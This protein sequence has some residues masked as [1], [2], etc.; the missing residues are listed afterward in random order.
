[1]RPHQPLLVALS[2]LALGGC[3]PSPMPTFEE[4][5]F[6]EA[7]AFL[8]VGGTSAD[9]VW[10][11]GAQT[12]PLG[13]PILLHREGGAWEEVPVPDTLH[14]LWWVHAFESGPVFVGGA[15]ATVLR[16]DGDTVERTPTPPFFGNTVFGVWGASPDDV[17]AVGGFAGRDAFAWHWDGAAWDVIDLPDNLPRTT[18]GE[19]PA[20]F[21]VWGR[22]TDDV[23]M[24][25]GLGLVLHWDGTSLTRVMSGTSGDLFTITGT[26]AEV[27]VVGGRQGNGLLLRGGM[28]GFVDDTP[29]GTQLIQAATFDHEGTLWVA[30]ASGFAARQEEGGSWESVDLGFATPPQVV[31]SM[32]TD[33]EGGVWGAGGRAL[34]PE[35]D[36]GVL[37]APEGTD[38]WTPT[39]EPAPD[40]SCPADLVDIAP[41]QS[42]A[43][44]WMELL[45]DSI[46]RDIPHPPVH[47]RNLHHV[48]VAMYDAWAT[49]QEVADGVVYTDRHTAADIESARQ[50][51]ISHAAYQVL[52]HRYAGAVGAETSLDCYD[53]FMADVL[54]LD[55]GDD[56]VTG[57]DPVA[58]GNRIGLAV[59]E[60]FASDGANEAGGYEDTTGWA[61]AN[62]V[63]VVDLPGTNVE[64]PD[65]WQ[66]LNLGTAETQNG[67]V[68]DSSVQPYIGPHWREVEPFAI[69]PD[70]QTG[71]YS[72]SLGAAPGVA[73]PVT[74]EEVVQVIRKT[75]ELDVDDGV[76]IDIGPGSLGN[77]SLGADDGAGYVLNPVTGEP[78]APN[79]VPRGDFTRVVAEIWADG[80]KSTTPPG[81][82]MGLANEVSDELSASELIPFGAGEPVDRLSWDV[83]LYLTVSGAVHDAAISAWE[84]KRQSLGPRPIT[85]IR[86]MGQNGQR[87]DPGLASY[88][89]DGLPLVP[90]LIELITAES[91]APGERHHHLRYHVGEI[92]V[93]SWPGEPGDREREYTP[94]QWMRVKDWIPYQRRT[95]VTPAFPGFT[96]GH[97]TFSRAAAE[98][99]TAYTGSPWFPGGLHSFTLPAGNTLI[100]EAG[101]TVD[102]TLQWASYQDAADQAGQSRLWGGIHVFA[103]DRVGRINGAM[104]GQVVAEHARTFVQGTAR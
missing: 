45:F 51:A 46:R 23:W 82:W 31:H 79:V 55:P 11:A 37:F 14:D 97:S 103:D 1:M 73:D 102:V 100:F 92:A 86:W 49:F 66:Q 29:A 71:M 54:A 36:R 72:D 5:A 48:S 17:W 98:A 34:S 44:R 3:P 62:P 22:S 67:I 52:S 35:L 69:E 91:A 77:N 75:A 94:L 41:D 99:L 56:R 43:R 40:L 28:D 38:V 50:V 64:L 76:Q 8:S 96:S 19:I 104:V 30:G 42:I 27:V 6:D 24:A 84:L 60:R 15:G 74:V 101:P 39:P 18:E 10:V 63:M 61:P 95:F 16:I 12:S 32:W 21:K 47:A 87:T 85:L 83:G 53:A 2:A 90:G 33:G 25:G 65:I 80:P 70:P 89:E 68:L 20:L 13:P 58:I 7:A 88:H 26:D 59:I 78:Y 81:H 93:W 9:D 57:D 4:V